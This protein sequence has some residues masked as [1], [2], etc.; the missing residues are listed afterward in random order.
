MQGVFASDIDPGT[1]Q[2]FFAQDFDEGT[3][4]YDPD[5][6]YVITL[7]QQQ[8]STSRNANHAR[9]GHQGPRPHLGRA[10]PPACRSATC[11]P[12]SPS[13]PTP[14][15][16]LRHRQRSSAAPKV[17]KTERRRPD[18]DRHHGTT[19]P[20]CPS[21]RSRQL[22]ERR[23]LHRQRQ[24]RLSSSRVAPGSTWQRFGVG[25]PNVQVKRAGLQP[26]PQHAVRRHLRPR[27]VHGLPRR[28]ALA[29]AG[30]SA[31]SAARRSGPARSRSPTPRS[32]APTPTPR[33]PSP[34]PSAS[35][36]RQQLQLIKKGGPASSSSPAPT[37]TAASPTSHEGVLVA[38]NPFAL[39]RKN[40]DPNPGP[41]WT[42]APSSA[43]A[44]PSS[45]SPTS[46]ASRSSL[47]GDGFSFNGHN[48]GALRNITNNN[49][50]TG[51]DQ[52]ARPTST[53]GV[54]SGSQ[55]TIAAPSATSAATAGTIIRRVD[56]CSQGADRH[57][58]P[59]PAPTPTTGITDVDQ[60][61]L[62]VQHASAWASPPPGQRHQRPR[63]R[64]APAPAAT[65][66]SSANG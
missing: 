61:A 29:N 44:P 11:S 13:I 22:Q 27:H 6:I 23:R 49:T 4:S 30:A 50:F 45:S 34:A 58:G 28:L 5:T 55:L 66:P 47:N 2:P 60:G 25:L 36:D 51:T 59:E 19:C 37:P 35:P 40:L 21:T 56:L 42:P 41:G 16:R 8:C 46:S 39:G 31:P 33:S 62:R 12:T 17:F 43:T 63:R 64:P 3:D 18:L 15:H 24:R 32:S 65:S 53:I 9:V 7:Q 48:T 14:R 38:R 10:R 20:T 26:D 57:A 54:D 52:L 1:L